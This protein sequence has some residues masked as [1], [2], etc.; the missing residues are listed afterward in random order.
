MLLSCYRACATSSNPVLLGSFSIIG[1][2]LTVPPAQL[3]QKRCEREDGAESGAMEASP[4]YSETITV[5][6][7]RPRR[8]L[9]GCSPV[10][11]VAINI[12]LFVFP[13]SPRLIPKGSSSA[14]L[15]SSSSLPDIDLPAGLGTL[16]SSL[17]SSPDFMLN[18]SEMVTVSRT[19]CQPTQYSVGMPTFV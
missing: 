17:R 5:G 7:Y 13:K 12:C 19:F 18:Y 10:L 14:R 1:P 6:E 8:I 3:Y 2:D 16:L 11:I 9:F 4:L 15:K